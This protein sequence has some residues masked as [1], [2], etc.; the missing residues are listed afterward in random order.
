LMQGQLLSRVNNLTISSG[1]NSV[2]VNS[3][4]RTSE[5]DGSQFGGVTVYWLE[6]GAQK[7][8]TKPQ[9]D[10]IRL[11]LHKIAGLG[12]ATDEVLED[13]GLLGSL[14]F[15]VLTV[16]LRWKIESA[17]W[18]GNGTAK[19]LG[20]ANSANPALITVSKEANQVA[21]TITGQNLLD[22]WVRFYAESRG[23]TRT[24]AWFINQDTE[25]QLMAASLPVGM[26]GQL[27]LMPANGLVGRPFNTIL[28]LPVVPV[29][30]A[31]TLGTVGDI[32]LADLDAYYYIEKG[33]IQTASSIHLFFDYDE[34]AFR[35]VAR[36]DGQP[37]WKT[38]L[39][40]AVGSTTTS[41][42]VA[43]QTRA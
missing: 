32:V 28:G 35:A 9:F 11:E 29:S 15:R 37:G 31:S 43:L 38:A 10:Y 36:V 19:P 6:E 22:M 21:T 23:A 3:L 42:F 40:P 2:R 1:A 16:A 17:V 27:M 25:A 4:I 7:Q 39:T 33:G 13:V 26:G 41:P 12:V 24:A 18:G 5:A 34:T 8:I 20:F 30:Y 14:I